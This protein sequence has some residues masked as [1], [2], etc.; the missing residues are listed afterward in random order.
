MF[1]KS[2]ERFRMFNLRPVSRGSFSMFILSFCSICIPSL[3]DSRSSDT[4]SS[5]QTTL[6]QWV[7][8]YLSLSTTKHDYHA[9]NKRVYFRN[10]LDFLPRLWV[11]L[12]KYSA[13]KWENQWRIQSYFE[14][15]I[16]VW[17]PILRY[18]NSQKCRNSA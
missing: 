7:C 8:Q 14:A 10:F 16:P 2:C 13:L 18:A 5:Y 1:W 12:W 17:D 15:G 3:A 9:Q 11:G 6:H 4:V